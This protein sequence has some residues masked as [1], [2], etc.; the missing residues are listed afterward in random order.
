MGWQGGDSSVLP[1]L[2]LAGADGVLNTRQASPWSL[3][4]PRALSVE[5]HHSRC[6]LSQCWDRPVQGEGRCYWGSSGRTVCPQA[7]LGGRAH[8]H[9]S[10][11]EYR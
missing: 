1:C 11:E 6:T 2:A 5:R 4:G 7:H 9:V 3:V 10:Q 8:E